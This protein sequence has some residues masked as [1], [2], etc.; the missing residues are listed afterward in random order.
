MNFDKIYRKG[1]CDIYN[2]GIHV[3]AD[4]YVIK[5]K[6]VTSAAFLVAYQHG[7]F[8]PPSDAFRALASLG[9]MTLE[10]A[11][12]GWGVNAIM[13]NSSWAL[14][15]DCAKRFK[16]AEDKGRKVIIEDL[17]KRGLLPTWHY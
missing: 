14:C 17:K 15:S 16:V 6:V 4:R 1:I 9:V 8:R 2:K 12:R 5:G 7:D 10:E 13:S 11:E 3:I